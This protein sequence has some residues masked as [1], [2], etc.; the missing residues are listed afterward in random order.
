M[1]DSSDWS[2]YLKSQLELF[3]EAAQYI[4]G[5][6]S[7]SRPHSPYGDNWDLLWL[8]H[9]G[10]IIKP[11]DQRRFIIE[12]DNTVPLFDHRVVHSASTVDMQREGLDERTR[13]TYQSG[14]GSCIYAYA[15]SA[16]GAKKVLQFNSNPK[17]FT[18]FDEGLSTLCK[19]DPTFKCLSVF[20]TLVDSHTPAGGEREGDEGETKWVNAHT[21]NILHSA[22]MTVDKA[23]RGDP[24]GDGREWRQWGEESMVEG[25]PRTRTMDRET[26]KTKEQ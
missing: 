15:L 25:P 7:R 20:P 26:A 18:A 6:P 12:N 1:T 23:L 9:C 13:L 5:T 10:S 8:G 22:Q 4:L 3:A 16:S 14:G 2:I 21:F 19:D 24:I 11:N 17:K